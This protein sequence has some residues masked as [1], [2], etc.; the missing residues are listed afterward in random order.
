MSDFRSTLIGTES[1]RR[2]VGPLVTYFD[3][4]RAPINESNSYLII[5]PDTGLH[6]T[7]CTQIQVAALFAL[8][9]L[10]NNNDNDRVAQLLTGNVRQR[11]NSNGSFSSSYNQP[12]DAPDLQDIAEIGASANALYYL[13][14]MTNSAEARDTLLAAAEYILSQVALENPGAIYK[15]SQARHVDVLNGDVYAALTLSRAFELSGDNRFLFQTKLV[16]EHVRSRFGVENDGWWPYAE[17]WDG[18]VAVGASLAYQATIIGFGMPIGRSLE[19]EL[20]AE[21]SSTLSTALKTVAQKLPLGPSDES[22][23]PSWSRDWGNVWEIPLAFAQFPYSP[24]AQEY[25]RKRLLAVERD[26]ELAGIEAL[27]P[28]PLQNNGRTPVT[29]LYRKA[30]TFAGFLVDI[31]LNTSLKTVQQ[32]AEPTH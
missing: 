5:D 27:R 25:V 21:W 24:Y 15:S 28:K 19:P 16:V 8:D 2:I 22:E 9:S 12:L 4:L 1:L 13:Y 3:S 29:S 11:Q 20:R 10:L 14:Q 7:C 17:T 30:A 26:I 31:L 23:A 32:S 18:K 6:A